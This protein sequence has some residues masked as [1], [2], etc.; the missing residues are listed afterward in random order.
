MIG[1][2]LT[3]RE[4]EIPPG[5]AH[6]PTVLRVAIASNLYSFFVVELVVGVLLADEPI[7]SFHSS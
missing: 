2:S 5:I 3:A 7:I 4:Q 1:H 6:P